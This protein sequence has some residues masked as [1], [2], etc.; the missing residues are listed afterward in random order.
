[1]LETYDTRSGTAHAGRLYGGEVSGVQIY[2]MFFGDSGPQTFRWFTVRSIRET[3]NKVVVQA[4]KGPL[5]QVEEP[6][7]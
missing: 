3:S 2:P 6:A 4:L 1:M 5:P 7:S